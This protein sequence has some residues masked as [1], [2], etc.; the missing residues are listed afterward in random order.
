MVLPDWFLSLGW[1]FMLTCLVG[2]IS[3]FIV[4][5]CSLT[6]EAYGGL[7]LL[8]SSSC[9]QIFHL[10]ASGS[11]VLELGRCLHAWKFLLSFN[12][13]VILYHLEISN[14]IYPLISW[15]AFWLYST[16]VLCVFL[17]TCS[18]HLSWVFWCN[19]IPGIFLLSL[20]LTAS[21]IP[22][23]RYLSPISLSLPLCFCLCLCLCFCLSV[24]LSLPFQG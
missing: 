6:S 20:S 11:W 10:S 1:C 12:C 3:P 4:K 16:W 15:G 5:N 24:F 18:A 19:S 14:F 23:F 21:V 13:G 9:S 22:G 17:G 8:W 2:G 7:N